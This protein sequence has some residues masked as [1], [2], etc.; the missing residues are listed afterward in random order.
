MILFDFE[1]QI[2]DEAEYFGG[3]FDTEILGIFFSGHR[4]RKRKGNPFNLLNRDPWA[5]N[6]RCKVKFIPLILS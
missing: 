5:Q 1:F 6:K 4:T 3:A 2:I